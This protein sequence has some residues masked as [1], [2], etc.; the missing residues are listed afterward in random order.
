MPDTW[1]PDFFSRSPIFDVL[2]PERHAWLKEFSSWPPVTAYAHMLAAAS[3]PVLSPSGPPIR[4]VG[5]PPKSDQFEE[6]YE[7]RIYLKGEVQTRPGWHD[8][9]NAMVWC[10][11][12]R[13][14]AVINALHY[15][16]MKETAGRPPARGTLRDVLT[17][18]DEN[19]A[20]VLAPPHLLELIREFR[21]KELFWTRRREVMAQMKVMVFGHAVFEKALHPYIG[22]TANALLLEAPAGFFD[23]SLATQAQCVDQLVADFLRQPEHLTSTRVLNPL[24]LLGVPGWSPEND[25]AAFYDNTQYFRPGRRRPAADAQ[26]APQP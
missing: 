21:W 3:Q 17:L 24:P 11:F 13:S 23:G 12:P 10:L 22:L 2:M 15:Q 4:F 8:F 14:K 7:P 25:V 6:V 18:L 16:V 9:F 20:V 1:D 26:N 5:Q 19:G